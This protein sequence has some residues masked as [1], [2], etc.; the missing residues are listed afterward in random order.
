[1]DTCI[2]A[3][4]TTRAFVK[5]GGALHVQLDLALEDPVKG[6]HLIPGRHSRPFLCIGHRA[7]VKA[8]VRTK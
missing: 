3:G 7:G 8:K 2:L 1:M 5:E 6:R 4:K